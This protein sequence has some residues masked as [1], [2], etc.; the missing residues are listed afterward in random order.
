MIQYLYLITHIP[1]GKDDVIS[2]F[3]ARGINGNVSFTVIHLFYLNI[4]CIILITPR[5]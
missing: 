2:V 1:S 5:W 4:R 3:E